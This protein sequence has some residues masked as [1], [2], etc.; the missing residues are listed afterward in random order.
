[1]KRFAALLCALVAAPAAAAGDPEAGATIVG[2]CVACHG[3]G[4]SK[5]ILNYPI[6]AGQ[7][8][9]YLLRSL[10]AYQNGSRNNQVMSGQVAPFSREDLENMAAYF[11]AQPSP[12]R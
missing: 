9:D 1:M 8:Q 6:I 2:T 5:P 12:L 4:G 7:H 3:E 10:L 11:A